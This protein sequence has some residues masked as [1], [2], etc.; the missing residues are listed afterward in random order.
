MLFLFFVFF[1]SVAL[2]ILA[3]SLDATTDQPPSFCRKPLV[4]KKGPNYGTIIRLDLQFRKALTTCILIMR[5]N[6]MI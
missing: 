4:P 5:Y 2:L 1:S 3:A 6:E